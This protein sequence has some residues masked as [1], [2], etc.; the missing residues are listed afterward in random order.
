VAAE[1]NTR[2]ATASKLRLIAGALLSGALYGLSFP[3]FNI[4]QLAWIALAPMLL[5][6]AG[7]P[8]QN[9]L[10]GW[11]AGF[12]ANLFI[13]V[14]ILKTFQVANVGLGLGLLCWFALAALLGLYFG[15][16]TF[17][18][19]KLSHFGVR[20]VLAAAAWVGL[21]WIRARIMTGFPW[22]LLAHTQAHQLY[23]LQMVHWTG[24]AGLSFLIVF[25][26]ASLADVL[27]WR[28]RAGRWFML[29]IALVCAAWLWG[30]RVIDQAAASEANV[31]FAR[32]AILQGNIDQYQKW[33]DAYE[34]SIRA[35]YENLMREA[36]AQ[37]PELIVWP[38]S[39][40]PGWFP[41]QDNYRVWVSSLVKA[42]GA[43]N[44][45]G[46]VTR[47]DGHDYNA[48]FLLDPTGA[49]VAEYDKRHMVPFGEYIPFGG[50]LSR[51][52]PYLG[53]LGTF[54]AGASPILFN[55]GN[56]R[57]SPNIC[58]EAMFAPLVRRG[59]DQGA[60]AIVNITNDGWFLDTNA[61][62]EHYVVNLFR[63]V[64]N[65]TP[66]IRAANTGISA[67]IDAYGQEQLR[68]PLLKA[69]IFSG[70]VTVSSPQ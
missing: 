53:Q 46:A 21:E 11:L 57:I 66:V 23:L 41:N 5:C 35:R 40:V 51:W 26:N 33:D 52:V 37:K 17:V 70:I 34:A 30:K 20:P 63:A 44:I 31:Q 68:S 56:L 8:R 22:A 58:Y 12:V 27:L 15:A 7:S 28:R 54:S 1:K 32:V 67:I 39:A 9:F 59:V 36:V 25:V 65:R 64:E 61:P 47:H 19:G 45:V 60:N 62:E 16:F 42:S 43:Y 48:A 55:A 38:E 29:A 69:G 13:F 10:V 24:A 49:I 6:A 2:S 4:A 50:F 3:S 18:Y 14:W